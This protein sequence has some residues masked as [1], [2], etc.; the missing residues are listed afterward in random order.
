[1][2]AAKKRPSLFVVDGECGETMELK[3][4]FV[5]FGNVGRAFARLLERKRDDLAKQYGMTCVARAIVT[6]R[7]GSVIS[8]TVLDLAEAARRTESGQSLAGLEQSH[9]VASAEEAIARS[10]ANVMFETTPLSPA[11]GEPA[12]SHIQHALTRGMSVVTANKGPIAH[13][14]RRL[15]TLAADHGVMFRFEGI[16]MDGCPV[17]NLVEF[18]LPGARVLSFA[19]VLNSTTNLVLTGMEEG[20]SMDECLA[21]AQQLGIAEARPDYDLDAWDSAIKAVALANVLMGAEVDMNDV[22]RLGISGLSPQEA[23]AARAEGNAIR[24]VA[25]GDYSDGKTRISV[26]PERLSRSSALGSVH[27]TSN[28]LILKT[29]VMGDIAIFEND[30]GIE[31]TAYALLSDLI[32]IHQWMAADSTARRV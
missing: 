6:G 3:L 9:P 11:G 12:I 32:R 19:G 16:V 20:R 13:A 27:G 25:R 31:Q 29:D 2:L 28:V 30:P 26:K 14:Y 10:N 22:Q 23:K 4:A 18:C 5:G 1:M 21:E 17:F 15:S 24:L 7:H 8:E